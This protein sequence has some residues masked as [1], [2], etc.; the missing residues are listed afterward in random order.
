VLGIIIGGFDEDWD[1]SGERAFWLVLTV[2]GAV[3]L[4]AGLWLVQRAASAMAVVALIVIGAVMGAVATFWTV[5]TGIV[6]IA[7]IV[8]AVLWARQRT[9]AT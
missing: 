1:S 5:I 9:V 3:L 2:G 4:A 8:L 7:V 6:A